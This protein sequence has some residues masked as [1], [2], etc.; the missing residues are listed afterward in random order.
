MKVSV[1]L[2][3]YNHIRFIRQAV[4]SV[5]AQKTDFDFE[6]LIVED[7]SADG[8][9]E[10]VID[11]ANRYP[12]KIRLQLSPVNISSNTIL[13][14][15]IGAARGEFIAFLDGDDYWTSPHKL[16]KQLDFM[17]SHPELTLCWHD[18]RAWIPKAECFW[19]NKLWFHCISA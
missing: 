16:Q 6:V 12:E 9:R 10:V 2:L 17:T 8:T 19:A 11:F 15:A 13:M 18:F 3:T 7:C 5:L 1:I 14:D 4:S